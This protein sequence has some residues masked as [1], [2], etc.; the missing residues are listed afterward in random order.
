MVL[1]LVVV[2]LA[3]SAILL[4]A[5]APQ[6]APDSMRVTTAEG[7]TTS[8]GIDTIVV[9][10]AK[11]TAHFS[12]AKKQ[13]RL[14]G[15]AD[16]KYRTQ[17]LQSEV[18]VMDF[19]SSTMQAD[20]ATDSTGRVAGFPV[21]SDNGEEYAGRSMLYNFSTRRGRVQFGETNIEGGYYYGSKIKRVDENTAFVEQG[22]F[23]TCDAPHPHFYFNSP[24]MKV[25]MNDKIYLDPIIWYVEDIPV[26]ALPIGMFFSTERGRRSG[27]I[28]PTPLITSDRGVVLQNLGY[29]FAV[30]DYFDTELTTDL[31]TKGGFTLYNRTNYAVRDKLTGRAKITFGYTRFNVTDPYALNLGVELNH[32]QQLRPNESII[33]DLLFTSNRLYQNTSLNPL[34][35]V[36]QNAR[37]NASYQRT[38]YNGMTFNTGYT[39]DQNMITGS[40]THT[41][42]VSFGIPQIQ[43]LKGLI[44]GDHW[45]RDLQFSYRSTARYNYNS[46]RATDTGAFVVNER[47]VWEHRPSITVTPKLGNFI[48]APS[49]S[50]SENWY[51]QR[52]TQSVNPLDSEIVQTRES[53]FF[54]EYTYGLGVNAST[55]LYG[56]ANPRILGIN[57]IRHTFQPSI[58][59]AY[60]PDQSDPSKGFYGEYVSPITGQTVRYN[61]FGDAGQLASSRQQ[62]LLTGSFLNRVAIKVKQG[63][64]ADKA[65]ELFTLNFA[66]S[67]NM[68]ADSLRLAPISFNLRTPMLDAV[69]FNLNGAFSVYDQALVPDPAT[70]RLVWKDMGT[71]M[72][73]AGKGLAR[74]SNLSIQLGTRFS[75]Q[76]VSFDQRSNV[77]DTSAQDSVREDLRSR[78]DRRLNYRDEDVDLFGERTPGWS[79]VIM[80]WDLGLQLVYSY[81]RPNP[82]VVSQ[83][84][85]LSFRGSVSLTQSLDMNVVG[86]FDLITGQ[87]NSP[88]IDISKRIHCWYLSVNWVPIGVNQGFFLRFGAS[89]QQLRDLVIPKQSTPLYR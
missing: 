86:S 11:D 21:F 53:G 29:Y 69:E 79:P 67:Y 16:V 51:F 35:R 75:S 68:V 71:S 76:G 89:A 66:T 65:I 37:S 49:I 55:F 54:R 3:T 8:S 45:L 60:I 33:L 5:Q 58:G 32:Q 56:L 50:Y 10:S 12:V 9:F 77:A 1:R 46:Y 19:G 84:L 40:I 62:F 87:L 22:C 20:G 28:M 70:G 57:S 73:Q 47:S 81:A 6:T 85:Y 13:L 31:T 27:I 23:T 38:F 61:R 59:L 83:S 39:R 80:P 24:Q 48:V 43:P 7:Q 17:R 25:V 30:S 74:L 44:S 18:I 26:F 15:T 36:R 63:D 4:R 82:D 42:V 41:P 2:L 34:D 88:I 72:L 52:Y 64:T 78:F 14:R